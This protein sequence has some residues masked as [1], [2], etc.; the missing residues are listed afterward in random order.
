MTDLFCGRERKICKERICCG[1]EIE[2][3]NWGK[4]EG[5]GYV[6]TPS[7]DCIFSLC[8]LHHPNRAVAGLVGRKQGSWAWRERSTLADFFLSMHIE[9]GLLLEEEKRKTKWEDNW[10]GTRPD[11]DGQV[12]VRVAHHRQVDIIG[13][14]VALSYFFLCFIVW[15]RISLVITS[16]RELSRQNWKPEEISHKLQCIVLSMIF[17]K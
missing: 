1:G 4:F 5:G 3:C 12:D 9:R 8:R 10:I 15:T 2:D 11:T 7:I 13:F 14:Q 6:P 17:L 16:L